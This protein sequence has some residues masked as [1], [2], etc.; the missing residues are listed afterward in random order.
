MQID[1]CIN[2]NQDELLC[3]TNWSVVPRVGEFVGIMGKGWDVVSVS[4]SA[5]IK[6]ANSD[7]N[8]PLEADPLVTV[9]LK[10]AK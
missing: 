8:K 5:Y 6:D 7:S 10:E 2:N 3:S 4:Y 9:F 1:F